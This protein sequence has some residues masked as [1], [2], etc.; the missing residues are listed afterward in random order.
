[1]TRKPRCSLRRVKGQLRTWSTGKAKLVTIDVNVKLIFQ[2][3]RRKKK[4]RRHSWPWIWSQY[5][6]PKRREALIQWQGVTPQNTGFLITC[7]LRSVFVALEAIHNGIHHNRF[8]QKQRSA[9]SLISFKQTVL[10]VYILRAPSSGTLDTYS[11][12]KGRSLKLETSRI[13]ANPLS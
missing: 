5:D 9:S 7:G 8:Y 13:T 1:M 10:C 4:N 11:T 2:Y 12:C 3:R 6:D